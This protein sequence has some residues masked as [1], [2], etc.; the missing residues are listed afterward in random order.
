MMKLVLSL[1]VAFVAASSTVAFL[2][3]TSLRYATTA[4]AAS[5]LR[6]STTSTSLSA[7]KQ[8]SEKAQLGDV[9]EPEDDSDRQQSGSYS[10]PPT[11]EEF[12][13][14]KQAERANEDQK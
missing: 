14:F 1:L 7:K 11:F 9:H 4:I 3:A 5:R 12:L 8:K 10:A 2:P 6:R 13:K